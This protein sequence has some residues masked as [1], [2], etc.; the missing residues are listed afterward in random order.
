MSPKD[1]WNKKIYNKKQQ[2]KNIHIKEL[3]YLIDSNN[4]INI[5]E[6]IKHIE[7]TNKNNDADNIDSCNKNDLSEYGEQLGLLLI[8]SLAFIIAYAWNVLLNR[9]VDKHIKNSIYEHIIYVI[10]ITLIATILI[11]YIGSYIE[12]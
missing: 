1:H 4:N 9:L 10:G 8:A 3:L 12:K 11:Y 7:L 2:K 6:L 5:D